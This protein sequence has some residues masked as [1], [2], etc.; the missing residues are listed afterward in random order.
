VCVGAAG[1]GGGGVTDASDEMVC[2]EI[3]QLVHV[4]VSEKR[5]TKERHGR[6]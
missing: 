2:C 3:D 5:M 6:Q 4:H 1:G